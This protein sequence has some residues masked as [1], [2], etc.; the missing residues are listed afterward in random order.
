MLFIK[1]SKC[2]T[3]HCSLT[4]PA[5]AGAVIPVS[6]GSDGGHCWPAGVA[7]HRKS[8]EPLRTTLQFLSSLMGSLGGESQ[9]W[10]GLRYLALLPRAVYHV[11]R[12]KYVAHAETAAAT[13]TTLIETAEIGVWRSVFTRAHTLTVRDLF[14]IHP[15]R[16]QSKH[17]QPLRALT[18][19]N[20]TPFAAQ[21]ESIRWWT[22]GSRSGRRE[23]TLNV[24]S[25]PCLTQMT[26]LDMLWSF[27]ALRLKQKK[28]EG[29]R[30]PWLGGWLKRWGWNKYHVSLWRPHKERSEKKNCKGGGAGWENL[31]FHQD[32]LSGQCRVWSLDF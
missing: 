22:A 30:K 14:C 16:A 20:L 15:I 31:F 2:F 24:N 17:F 32:F 11:G 4:L 19:L 23:A 7:A 3:V 26:L 25:L 1:T 28:E 21:W 13:F 9:G 5:G 27:P 6:E 29:V 18:Q 10:W 8:T 12:S